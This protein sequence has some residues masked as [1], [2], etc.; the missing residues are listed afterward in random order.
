VR[1]ALATGLTGDAR[2]GLA[3][4][5]QNISMQ[6]PRAAGPVLAGALFHAGWLTVPF[7]IGAAFQ[8]AY[9]VLYAR[10]FGGHAAAAPE[11]A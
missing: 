3:S 11:S 4:S 9:L 2:R 6:V 10:F 1:Q 5:L 8:C 7:V